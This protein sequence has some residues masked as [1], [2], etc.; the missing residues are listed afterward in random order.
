MNSINASNCSASKE[1]CASFISQVRNRVNILVSHTRHSNVDSQMTKLVRSSVFGNRFINRWLS[2]N[3]SNPNPAAP[4]VGQSRFPKLP[5]P[6][7][8]LRREVYVRREYHELR[9]REIAAATEPKS[10][11]PPRPL[12]AGVHETLHI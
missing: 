12:H 2:A 1:P 11:K 3:R 8:A 10:G 9:P 7:L 5:A 6:P 4:P